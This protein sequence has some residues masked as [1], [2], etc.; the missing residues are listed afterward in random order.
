[1]RIKITITINKNYYDIDLL[2]G[3][4]IGD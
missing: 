4:K 3:L 2:K 1:M